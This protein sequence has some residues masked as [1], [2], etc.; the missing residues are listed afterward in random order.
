MENNFSLLHRLEIG[1]DLVG[2]K[3]ICMDNM[4]TYTFV[5]AAGPDGSH[6]IRD[7]NGNIWT[8]KSDNLRMAPLCWVECKPVYPGDLLFTSAGTQ[9][10]ADYSESNPLCDNA[11]YDSV[12]RWSNPKELS[13]KKPKKKKKM[14]GWINI[15]LDPLTASC[16][17]A[18]ISHSFK[19][20]ELADD[21]AD[22]H[23]PRIKCVHIEWEEEE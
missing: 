9:V 7:Q 12:G 17:N 4:V 10:V 19:T 23:G 21:H 3:V 22:K 11:L 2:K 18:F 14:E 13:W 6:A 16:H 1:N 15:H 8:E 5:A 20:K